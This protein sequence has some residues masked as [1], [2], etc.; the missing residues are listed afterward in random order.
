MS[1][2]RG[3]APSFIYKID[4]RFPKTGDFKSNGKKYTLE[5]QVTKLIVY[6]SGV[7]K[8][9]VTTWRM[10]PDEDVRQRT[11]TWEV[12]PGMNVICLCRYRMTEEWADEY[13]RV[14]IGVNR[15]TD[16]LALHPTPELHRRWQMFK[17]MDSYPLP[18]E[19]NVAIIVGVNMLRK[20]DAVA[21]ARQENE[22]VDH[23]MKTTMVQMKKT[24]LSH[25]QKI[26]LRFNVDMKNSCYCYRFTHRSHGHGKVALAADVPMARVW[27]MQYIEEMGEILPWIQRQWA[28][29]CRDTYW[30]N[31]G[32][33]HPE[34]DY[35]VGISVPYIKDDDE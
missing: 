11:E 18:L 4:H 10:C 30:D 35:D 23:A 21:K 1:T 31:N 12:K 24:E 2:Y 8:L 26:L 17:I 15:D 28:S 19:E 32:D 9:D 14:Q 7:T 20:G 22:S 29:M 33:D 13:F 25:A 6:S 5:T 3:V 34:Y 27:D 16:T